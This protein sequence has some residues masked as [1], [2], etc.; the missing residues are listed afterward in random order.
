M[1][2]FANG[3]CAVLNDVLWGDVSSEKKKYDP[4]ACY[5]R[6]TKFTKARGGQPPG[7]ADHVRQ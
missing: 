7:K 6:P 2:V 1:H 3:K 4:E 5:D